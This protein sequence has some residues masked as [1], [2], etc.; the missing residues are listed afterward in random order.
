MT[1]KRKIASHK[2]GR[3]QSLSGR[4]TVDEKARI[5]HILENEEKSLPDWVMKQAE[6][7]EALEE[8]LKTA[9]PEPTRE[10]LLNQIRMYA[11]LIIQMLVIID[12]EFPNGENIIKISEQEINEKFDYKKTSEWIAGIENEN[13]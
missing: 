5:V 11:H 3:T 8:Y 13:L 6:R 2:G 4:F 10:D 1:T 7:A 9:Q 12:G